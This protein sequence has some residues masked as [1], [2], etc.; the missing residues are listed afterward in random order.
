MRDVPD[1][2]PSPIAG[3][4]YE[5]DPRLLGAQVDQFLASPRLPDLEGEVVAVIAPHAGYQYSGA[6]A[7]YAFRAVLG[8]QY[9]LVVVVSPM[10]RGYP[11]PLLTS[12]HRAY[13]TPLGNVAI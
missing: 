5:G 3:Q 6:V 10:H 9:D 12:A 2:R 13:V 8:Q 11:Y 1:L 4:W 7:G